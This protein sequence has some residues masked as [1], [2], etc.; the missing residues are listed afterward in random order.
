MQRCLCKHVVSKPRVIGN[1]EVKSDT[2]IV[3]LV[4]HFVRDIS[5]MRGQVKWRRAIVPRKCSLNGTM[6]SV[7]VILP[8]VGITMAPSQEKQGQIKKTASGNQSS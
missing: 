6:T 8:H 5:A 2:R 3:F 7:P 4:Y 1:P